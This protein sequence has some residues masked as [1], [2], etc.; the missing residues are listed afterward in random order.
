MVYKAHKALESHAIRMASD[1]V[2]EM[3][4]R[5]GSMPEKD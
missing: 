3:E 2:D 1:I 5:Y 4:R